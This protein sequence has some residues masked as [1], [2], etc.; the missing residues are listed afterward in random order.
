[1]ETQGPSGPFL[2]LLH[3]TPPKRM[4]G[5]KSKAYLDNLRQQRFEI[6]EKDLTLTQGSAPPHPEAGRHAS[7][8]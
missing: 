4:H 3:N 7:L 5:A 1:M 2:S 8:R 6:P